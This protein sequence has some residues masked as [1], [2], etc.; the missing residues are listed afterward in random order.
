MGGGLVGVEHEGEGLVLLADCGRSGEWWE[1]EDLVVVGGVG[2]EDLEGGDHLGD[3]VEVGSE[4][5]GALRILEGG[6]ERRREELLLRQGLEAAGLRLRVL[7]SG[8]F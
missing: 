4:P 5:G 6:L 1:A 7:L 3:A 8:R 2:A